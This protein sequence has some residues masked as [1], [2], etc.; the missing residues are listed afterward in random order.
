MKILKFDVKRGEKEVG[1]LLLVLYVGYFL[2]KCVGIV[3]GKVFC[4]KDKGLLE[5]VEYF[6]KFMEVEWN[7]CISYYLMMMLNDRR[8][9]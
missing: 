6:E 3:C 4:E 9:N 5:D 1:I 8:Y 7:Y 2:K